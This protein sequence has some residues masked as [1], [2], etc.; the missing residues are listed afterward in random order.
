[1]SSSEYLPCSQKA[2]VVRSGLFLTCPTP[3]GQTTRRSAVAQRSGLQTTV[4]TILIE[5]GGS[6]DL[7]L[8]QFR[9]LILAETE[10]GKDL[11]GLLAEFRRPRGHFARRAR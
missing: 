5:S 7:A 9:D 11:V 10:F 8:A 6:H 1:M 4:R 2:P 3:S